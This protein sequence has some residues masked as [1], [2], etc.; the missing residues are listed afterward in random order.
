MP[1]CCMQTPPEIGGWLLGSP[2]TGS[3]FD[4]LVPSMKQTL[5]SQFLCRPPML[6]L[7]VSAIPEVGGW[8]RWACRNWLMV[9]VS[10]LPGCLNAQTSPKVTAALKMLPQGSGPK[11]GDCH[12]PARLCV[13]HRAVQHCGRNWLQVGSARQ[14]SSDHLRQG[15][16]R[17]CQAA[18][19]RTR[20][21]GH[22][23]LPS[24]P[25][26]QL[27]TRLRQPSAALCLL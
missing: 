8:L 26:G 12:R 10:C 17:H 11:L 14:L 4:G 18:S 21:C 3:F 1:A 2:A 19:S 6:A 22:V 23:Q 7:T 27:A 20:P 13:T 16:V 5:G 25:S 24:V 15:Q 9:I